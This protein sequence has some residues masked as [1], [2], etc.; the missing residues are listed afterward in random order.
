M[1]ALTTLQRFNV[2][3][4]AIVSLG[5]DGRMIVTN[6]STQLKTY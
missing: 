2:W 1:Q 6:E 4:E 3:L 5:P